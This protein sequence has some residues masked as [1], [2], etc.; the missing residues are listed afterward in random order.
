MLM[1]WRTLLNPVTRPSRRWDY[2]VDMPP[3]KRLPGT[4]AAD[5]RVFSQ[6]YV[7]RLWHEPSAGFHPG[8]TWRASLFNPR[9]RR[10]RHFCSAATL[11]AY[12]A[13]FA[14]GWFQDDEDLGARA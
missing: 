1:C 3:D 4:T 12:L 9:S 7:L 13:A 11:T 8:E 2:R 14:P 10:R 6:I 5:Q